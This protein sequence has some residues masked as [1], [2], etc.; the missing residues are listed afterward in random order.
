[1]QPNQQPQPG[2]VIQPQ[3]PAQPQPNYDFT[4]PP[5]PQA[6]QPAPVQPQPQTFD[7]NAFKQ[8]VVSAVK[9][10]IQ[11][12]QPSQQPAPQI[13]PN[14]PEY[15]TKQYDDWG[16]LEQDTKKLVSDVID[17]KLNQVS[18]QQ[19]ESQKQIEE[20]EK[21]NQQVIDNTLNQLRG[22]GYLPAVANPFDTNDQGKQAEMELIGYAVSLGTTNLVE[23]AKELKFKHDSGL[24][25]DYQSKQWI[26][27]GQPQQ[28]GQSMFGELPLTPDSPQPGQPPVGQ[29]AMQPMQAQ[30][31]PQPVATQP[32]GPQNPY[33]QQQYPP[34]FNAP[35]ASGGGYGAV[36]MQGQVPNVSTI[37]HTSYDQLVDMF[38]R[39]Q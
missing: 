19:T 34:G 10:A 6:P 21:Q 13:Q 28:T 20:Q 23:A 31:Y 26:S 12:Q 3:P 5:A 2:Q 15:F 39:T 1:M 29:P 4:Q 37:R 8:E 25:Y 22:A 7:P 36:G 38:N 14:A 11:P 30:G 33:I 24:R 17:E 27:T 32:Y 35:V 16:V 9:D 18:Q